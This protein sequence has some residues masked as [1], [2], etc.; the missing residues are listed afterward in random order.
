[1]NPNGNIQTLKPWKPGQSGNPGGR[2]RGLARTVR[3]ECGGD[4]SSLVRGLLE[5]ASTGLLPNGKAAAGGDIVNAHRALLEHGWGKA[6]AFANIEGAD[7]LERDELDGAIL[8]IAES[9][10]AERAA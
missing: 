1:M 10:R 2:P 8:E 3:E 5:I 9:L 7:P 4:P 6:P